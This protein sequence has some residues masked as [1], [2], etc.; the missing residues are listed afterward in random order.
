MQ[1]FDLEPLKIKE[2]PP[3]WPKGLFTFALMIFLVAL[4][5]YFGL[6]YWNKN[7]NSQLV[8]LDEEFQN[9]RNSFALEQE[10]EVI[11][12]EKKLNVLSKLLTNHIYFSKV[13]LVLEE[14]THPDIYYTDLDFSTDKNILSL[15]GV[16][17]DQMTLSEAVSGLVNNPDKIKA[18]AVKDMKVTTNKNITFSLDVFIQPDLLKYQQDDGNY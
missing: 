7:Q 16:A 1:N 5:S 11:L 17:K 9:L 13:L 10:N 12:F 18:V 2:L 4:G 6:N 3:T 14:L 8:V 15:V